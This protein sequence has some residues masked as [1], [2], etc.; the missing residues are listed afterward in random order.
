GGASI[1]VNDLTQ[2]QI[3]YLFD[4]N[5]EPRWL[6]AQDPENN[7]P[8][9]PEIPILQFRGFCAV[10]EPAEVDFERVGTLGRGFDSETSGFWILDYSFD[11]PPSGTVERTDEVIRLT[12]PIECE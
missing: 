10:C 6:F 1:L 12:D 5:G 3:H 11:A 8:L 9:D 7:D 2:A 4:E